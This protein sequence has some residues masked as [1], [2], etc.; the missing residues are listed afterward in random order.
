MLR[1]LLT[2]HGAEGRLSPCTARRT[3][4]RGEL[5]ELPGVASVGI[6]PSDRRPF[7]I[8]YAGSAEERPEPD[9]SRPHDRLYLFL[10]QPYWARSLRPFQSTSIM[11]AMKTDE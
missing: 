2:V 8:S 11:P 3:V 9:G 7:P 10:P 1:E 4:V 5:C 6:Q